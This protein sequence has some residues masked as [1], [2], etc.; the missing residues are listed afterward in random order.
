MDRPLP[1]AAR[2]GQSGSCARN[3]DQATSS[4]Q[5][6]ISLAKVVANDSIIPLPAPLLDHLNDINR[7]IAE[8]LKADLE[9][10]GQDHTHAWPVMQAA[11]AGNGL[12]SIDSD[13][14]TSFVRSEA[15]EDC[16]CWGETPGT[17]PP[18]IPMSSWVIFA[19]AEIGEPATPGEINF[20]INEQHPDGWWSVFRVRHDDPEYASTYG[21]AW[22][23]LALHSQS[24]KHLMPETE[25]RSAASAISRGAS[26]LIRAREPGARWKDYPLHRNGQISESLSGLVLH[27]LHTVSSDR[28]QLKTIDNEWVRNLPTNPPTA[29]DADRVYRWISVRDKPGQSHLDAIVQI[30]LP[31]MLMATVDTYPSG[32]IFERAWALRWLESALWQETVAGADTQ[33][34][35]WW[36][37]ELLHGI[38]Y[39]L[40]STS[41]TPQASAALTPPAP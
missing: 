6:G 32:G 33:P 24:S 37:S 30:K 18:N 8:S 4:L 14:I 31:W 26:W 13:R 5:T 29:G 34:D 1:L 19:L 21:T 36:R 20:L 11:V 25:A 41:D 12:I 22:A 28:Q 10:L 9:Q 39:I 40:K 16:N 3:F 38:R 17:H 15:Y 23:I 27:A 2:D 7:R 35:N